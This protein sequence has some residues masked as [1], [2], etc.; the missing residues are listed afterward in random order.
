M[1]N[2]VKNDWL[3]GRVDT[4]FK[5][6]VEQYIDDSPSIETQGQLIRKAVMEY[7]KSHPAEAE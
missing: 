6:Q 5:E 3:G 4:D 7:M 2:K 1:A